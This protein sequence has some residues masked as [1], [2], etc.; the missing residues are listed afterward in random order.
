MTNQEEELLPTIP[1]KSQETTK[2][3]PKKGASYIPMAQQMK[4]KELYV[5][6]KSISAIAKK[7]KRDFK[8]V[9]KVVRSPEES[10]RYIMEC[11]EQLKDLIPDALETLAQELK[12]SPSKDRIKI[13]MLI[14][15]R[16]GVLEKDPSPSDEL[17]SMLSVPST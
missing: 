5:S 9:A 15:S 10:G 16:L 1:D 17:A 11:R 12:H 7:T 3:G 4:M 8:T 6:G 13:A 14:L 2:P